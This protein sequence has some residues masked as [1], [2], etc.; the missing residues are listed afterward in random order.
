MKNKILWSSFGFLIV[1]LFCNSYDLFNFRKRKCPT[2]KPLHFEITFSH[3]Q[4]CFQSVSEGPGPS[5]AYINLNTVEEIN[6]RGYD[7]RTYTILSKD[8][9]YTAVYRISGGK[10]SPPRKGKKSVL[11]FHGYGASA[12]SWI[13]QPGSRNLAFTLVDAGYEVWLGNMRGTT[14]SKNHTHLN[15][16][17]DLEYWKF[18]VESMSTLDLPPL[19]DLILRETETDKL[20][21]AC[22][23]WGC[24]MY[25][26]A[27]VDVPELNNKFK[28]GFFL[29][30]SVFFGSVYNPIMVLFP[31]VTGTP[32]ESLLFWLL[33]GKVNG[34]PNAIATS[35]GLVTEKICEWSYL[36]CGI[37]DN[38]LFAI[39]GTDPEQLDYAELPN[40][41]KKLQDNGA[42]NIAYH[43]HQIDTNCNFQRYDFGP[44]QNL[45]KYGTTKPPSYNLSGIS[46]PTYIFHA[47]KDNF[48][49]PWDSEERGMRFHLSI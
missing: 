9:Y 48:V 39:Y 10:N 36:R 43:A 1:A 31:P 21:Y 47:E 17:K 49:T 6:Y 32:L 2:Y 28:A 35:L 41:M 14:P 25:T 5:K 34:E 13:I 12:K 3:R 11:I 4:Q 45:L 30:P 23:S 40:I 19:V 8:G 16:D 18:G 46:V 15:A 20:Y 38:I 29:A 22:H 24:G 33:R 27:L 37:C 42:L 7:A 26:A 44:G